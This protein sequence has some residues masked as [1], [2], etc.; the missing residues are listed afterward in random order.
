MDSYVLCMS[1][2]ETSERKAVE[3][4]QEAAS[5]CDSIPEPKLIG[6]GGLKYRESNG[7]EFLLFDLSEHVETEEEVSAFINL[8]DVPAKVVPYGGKT[9]GIAV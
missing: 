3:A 8:I 9:V 2:L 5:V 7:G 4:V 6:E 1:T